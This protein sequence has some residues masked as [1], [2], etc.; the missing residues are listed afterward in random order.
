MGGSLRQVRAGAA[1]GH[2]PASTS[3]APAQHRPPGGDR[4][5]ASIGARTLLAAPE[6]FRAATRPWAGASTARPTAP[7]DLTE[8]DPGRTGGAHG[9]IGA[10]GC[11]RQHRHPRDDPPAAAV[12][13]RLAGPPSPVAGML[14]QGL[15]KVRGCLDS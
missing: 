7:A 13:Q 12:Q 5:D 15:G 10:A 1:A 4:Q 6:R 8:G 14:A 9:P 2:P 11:C 3:L